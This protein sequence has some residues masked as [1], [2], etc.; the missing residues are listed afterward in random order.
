[1]LVVGY[2]L[3]PTEKRAHLFTMSLTCRLLG[4]RLIVNK[5]ALYIACKPGTVS[6]SCVCSSTGTGVA[7]YAGRTGLDIRQRARS[8]LAKTF[9]FSCSRAEATSSHL[10][11]GFCL[12]HR[13]NSSALHRSTQRIAGRFCSVLHFFIW[14]SKMHP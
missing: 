11:L 7:R 12:S 10:A 4:S 14:D 3:P 6:C 9:S 2:R 13:S 5:W 8:S 1:M